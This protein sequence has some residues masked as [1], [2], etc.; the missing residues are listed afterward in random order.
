ME[1]VD[2]CLVG[3]FI[4]IVATTVVAILCHRKIMDGYHKAAA[5]FG[6]VFAKVGGKITALRKDI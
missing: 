4:G 3:V 6:F 5:T 1:F 2:G